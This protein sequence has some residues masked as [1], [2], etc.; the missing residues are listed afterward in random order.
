MNNIKNDMTIK[1]KKDIYEKTFIISNMNTNSNGKKLL[2]YVLIQ[3]LLQMGLL[4]STQFIIILIMIVIILVI[5]IDF[6]I[7]IK[8]LKKLN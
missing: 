7:T 2:I 8:N 1:I 6:I 3:I 4:K 5:Y